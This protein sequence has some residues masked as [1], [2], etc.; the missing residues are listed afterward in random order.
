MV[1]GNVRGPKCSMTTRSTSCSKRPLVFPADRLIRRSRIAAQK[2]TNPKDLRQL[3]PE[4]QRWK[5][6]QCSKRFDQREIR[7]PAQLRSLRQSSC[8]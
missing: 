3:L 8:T 6:R 4:L 7:L 2:A 5:E 1:D